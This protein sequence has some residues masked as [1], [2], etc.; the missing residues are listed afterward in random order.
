[1]INLLCIDSVT[2]GDAG[3]LRAPA[4][5]RHRGDTGGGQPPPNT[6]PPV[7]PSGL[8]EGAQWAPPGDKPMQNGSRKKNPETRG[9]RVRGSDGEGVQR[10]REEDAIGEG[11][12]LSWEDT[13][14]HGR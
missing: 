13:N 9:S 2:S 6:V 1:M 14:K 7:R 12:P 8:Q 3:A 11:V 5:P 4:R 10:L